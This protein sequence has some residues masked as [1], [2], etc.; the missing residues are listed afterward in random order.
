MGG[1]SKRAVFLDRDGT[2]NVRPP[3]HTYVTSEREFVWLPGAREGVARLARAGYVLTIVSNQRGVSRGLIAPAALRRIEEKIQRDLAV[4]GCAVE[5]FRYCFHGDEEGCDCRKPRPGMIL[6]LAQ[7]LDLELPSS[8]VIGDAP[9]DIAAG[10]AAGCL[11][12][13][14]GGAEADADLVAGSLSEASEAIVTRLE[15]P[16]YATTPSSNSSQSA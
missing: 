13:I 11:T 4:H 15:E 6:Q 7:D 8:W 9:S 3:E 1:L 10:K 2:L 12:A 14:V 5:R 16:S